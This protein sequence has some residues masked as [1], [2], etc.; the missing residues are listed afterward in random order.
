[1]QGN[2]KAPN[3]RLLR[4]GLSVPA[5]LGG[6]FAGFTHMCA[7]GHKGFEALMSLLAVV[8][9]VGLVW[10]FRSIK[11][12]VAAA[13]AFL[14]LMLLLGFLYKEW[15]HGPNSPWPPSKGSP[16]ATKTAVDTP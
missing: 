13:G 14:L 2:D 1:M 11:R 6:A 15:V 3:S 9:A 5:L 7:A 10:A 16:R 4:I 12:S 8:G